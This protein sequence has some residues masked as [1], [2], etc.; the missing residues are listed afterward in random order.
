M[1]I[2]LPKFRKKNIIVFVRNKIIS[3]DT[4]LPILMEMKK[5]YGVQSTVVVFDQLT[6]N[7]INENV[8]IR[9]ALKY[10]GKELYITKGEN[11]KILRRIYVIYYLSLLTLDCI[12]GA[13]LI[14]FY[15]LDRW[16]LK[17]LGYL[18]R[19]NVYRTQG[20]GYN[21]GYKKYKNISGNKPIKF[22]LVGKNR[23]SFKGAIPSSYIDNNGV[24]VFEFGPPRTR[25]VWLQYIYDSSDY[26][27][28]MYHGNVDVSSGIIVLILSS[29]D[30][31]STILRDPDDTQV[32]LFIKTID[33]LSK[34]SNGLPIFIKPHIYTNIKLLNNLIRN[35]RNLFVTYLHP[36]ML[37]SKSKVF[38]ANQ[39]SNTLAD[40][41][42]L[43]VTTIEHTDYSNKMLKATNH[44]SIDKKFVSY[45]INN[46][47]D[48]FEKTIIDIINKDFILKN[49]SGSIEDKSGLL[50]HLSS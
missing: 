21:F 32:E 9:D 4:I 14:H 48:L 38:I 23:V 17:I 49:I 2:K 41:Y 6:H 33:I 29:L 5:V 18:F 46:N 15:A 27:F 13:K 39:F 10:V 37:A 19:K 45:F 30:G 50:L 22:T 7:G 47:V 8:V 11:N 26:Y 43:G 16:P 36:T 24:T 25:S 31:R 35:K 28:S 34:N 12:R 42:S 3:M 1:I 20:S 40:A 44:E